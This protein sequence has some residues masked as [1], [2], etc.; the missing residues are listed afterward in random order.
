MRY[1]LQRAKKYQTRNEKINELEN[2][3][4]GSIHPFG[5]TGRVVDPCGVDSDP[6]L[7][8]NINRIRLQSEPQKNP[9]RIR[10]RP[11]LEKKPDPDPTS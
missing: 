1:N 10:N 11:T 8:S 4:N 9:I 5:A 6:D 3:Q 2:N 7:P